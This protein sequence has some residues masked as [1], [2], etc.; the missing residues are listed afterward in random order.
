VH[1]RGVWVIILL[2]TGDGTPKNNDGAIPHVIE[3]IRRINEGR[4]SR[5]FVSVMMGNC[6][7]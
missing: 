3:I 4:L 7:F 5:F 6:M 2:R 1:K